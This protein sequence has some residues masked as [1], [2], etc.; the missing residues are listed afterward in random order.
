MVD[1]KDESIFVLKTFRIHRNLWGKAE[2]LIDSGVYANAS[3]LIRAAIREL[4]N[5]Q[6]E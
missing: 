4:V 2:K 6:E 3:E 1:N 5:K